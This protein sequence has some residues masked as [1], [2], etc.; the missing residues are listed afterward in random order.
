VDLDLAKKIIGAYRAKI[1]D[2]RPDA[3]VQSD[4]VLGRAKATI[5]FAHFIYCEHL[6]E[7]GVFDDNDF[8]TLLESYGLLESHFVD[9]PDSINTQYREFMVKLRSGTITGFRMPNPFGDPS[10]VNEFY[11]FIGDCFVLH[12]LTGLTKEPLGAFI[13]EAV[14]TKARAE[15]DIK[16][17]REIAA[18]PITRALK[19]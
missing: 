1:R 13:Y 19:L 9:D 5:K 16:V 3:I 18:T 6:I 14:L 17:L 10:A 12:G 4:S 2:L 7:Q 11:N 15:N 8:K